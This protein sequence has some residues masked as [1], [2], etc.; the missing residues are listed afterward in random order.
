MAAL[1]LPVLALAADD[2]G[3]D[4]CRAIAARLASVGYVEC[5]ARGLGA[6]GATSVQGF[7][8]LM[9]DYGA[10]ADP[11]AIRALV[12]GGIHGDE[13]SSVSVIF[14]WMA[15]MEQDVTDHVHW[16]VLP[17]LNPDGLLRAKPQRM[18]ANGVDLNRNFPTDDWLRDSHEHWIKRTGANPRRYPGAT[19]MSE[20]EIHW[21]VGEIERF[22]PD[23]IVAIHAPYGILDFDG[24]VPAPNRLGS[25][26]L[27]A[28][29]TFPGSL[30][31][32]A[33]NK[34]IQ[35]VT[36]EL[37]SAGSM[38][39]AGEIERIWIDLGQWLHKHLR[40]VAADAQVKAQDAG[41][42]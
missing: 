31:N 22:K 38:P 30:G 16:R 13:L 2:G 34:G 4:P 5:Q 29:G 6:T 3:A 17:L 42:S 9:R 19:P 8:L 32:Y 11:D 21:L 25:L 39:S 20:P 23:L 1:L 35:V 15:R 24:A 28:L 18:N 14:K 12:I 36:V 41:P 7:P 27:N 10:A 33:S 40:P 37:P 26:Y